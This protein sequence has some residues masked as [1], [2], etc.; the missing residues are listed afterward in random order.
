MNNYIKIENK[1]IVKLALEK[2]VFKNSSSDMSN[3]NFEIGK[4]SYTAKLFGFIVLDYS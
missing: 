4:S 2:T 3:V 1:K